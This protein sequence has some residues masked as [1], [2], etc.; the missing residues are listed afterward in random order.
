ME[1]LVN[2]YEKLCVSRPKVSYT[3]ST[4]VGDMNR[5]R[6]LPP[7]KRKDEWVHLYCFTKSDR[8]E[9]MKTIDTGSFGQYCTIAFDVF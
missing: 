9:R 1:S 2:R 7:V 4:T 6:P 8:K 3:S 5:L